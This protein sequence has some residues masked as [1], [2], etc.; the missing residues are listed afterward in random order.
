M[1]V[2]GSVAVDV[3]VGLVFTY[4]VFSTLCSAVNEAVSQFFNRRGRSSSAR[5][6]ACSATA[7]PRSV[8]GITL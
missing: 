4:L 5:S 6:M 1:R 3:A 7:L 8:S 2:T